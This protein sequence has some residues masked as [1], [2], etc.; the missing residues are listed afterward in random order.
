M[1]DRYP[2]FKVAAVQAASVY[3]DR[4]GTVEKACQLILEA[5]ANGADLVVFSE[6]FIP[7]YPHWYRFYPLDHPICNR[8]NR[9]LFKNAVEIPSAS[10][11]L[12]CQAAK[13]ANIYV[14]AGLDEKRSGML[15]TMY[16][17]QLFIHRDGSILGKHQKLMPTSLE[18]LVHGLGDGSTLRVF[19]TEYGPI[20]CLC[21]G[22]NGNPLFRF[23]LMA[24]GEVVHVANWPSYT[25]PYPQRYTAEFMLLRV[26]NYAFEGKVFVVS[27]AEIFTEEMAD[28]IE[29]DAE[30]RKNITERGGGSAVVSPAGQYLAGPAEYGETI[31]Y[32]DIDLEELIDARMKQDFTGHYNRFDVVSLNYN[33]SPTPPLHYPVCEVCEEEAP[34]ASVK[35]QAGTDTADGEPEASE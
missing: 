11:D 25:S 24:Q 4:E 28:I 16:N 9:E 2:K 12:L 7:G 13:E 10:T 23:A 26:R 20:G 14:V 15:G 1:G 33:P 27:S 30:T 29:L 8:L 21:C 19:P 3:L 6:C 18:R 22:E 17:T 5:G 31:I 34:P 35:P 32:A